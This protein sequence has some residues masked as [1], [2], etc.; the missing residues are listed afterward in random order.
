ME[1]L[2]GSCLV[3][4]VNTLSVVGCLLG[5]WLRLRYVDQFSES[6]LVSVVV[7]IGGG[8]CIPD[9]VKST[10]PASNFSETREIPT[11]E[12]GSRLLPSRDI[13]ST[14]LHCR[15]FERG[16]SLLQRTD[17]EWENP[18]VKGLDV[19]RMAYSCLRVGSVPS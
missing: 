18:T 16:K 9:W 17:P 10:V 3:C 4:F 19:C 13:P 5:D 6:L 1:G 15:G 2:F 11:V 12:L 14:E 7:M 8:R